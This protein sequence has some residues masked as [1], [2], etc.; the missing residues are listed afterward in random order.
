VDLKNYL[1]VKIG[2]VEDN[3]ELLM[4]PCMPMSKDILIHARIEELVL[5]SIQ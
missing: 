3:Y 4:N 5:V 1:K 2:L